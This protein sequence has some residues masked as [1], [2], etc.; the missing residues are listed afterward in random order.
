MRLTL[1]R[2]ML[3][4]RAL[5]RWLWPASCRMRTVCSRVGAA[6]SS[7][8]ASRASG[9]TA[10]Y[11]GS[12]PV[13]PGQVPRPV[14]VSIINSSNDPTSARAGHALTGPCPTPCARLA[15]TV[16]TMPAPSLHHGQPWCRL[17]PAVGVQHHHGRSPDQPVHRE[18][19]QPGCHAR[20]AMRAHQFVG[21][22]IGDDR[23]D[24]GH[25]HG[26]SRATRV[27]CSPGTRP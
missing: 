17:V 12:Q 15:P 2:S 22:L 26:S 10:W 9:G 27:A 3:S 14:R 21:V 13:S 7:G 6:L 5:A 19:Q 18:R 25:A 23:G 16:A 8:G 20:L 4:C 24:D 1:R 11:G